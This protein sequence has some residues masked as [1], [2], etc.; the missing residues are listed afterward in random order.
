MWLWSRRIRT[1]EWS[2]SSTISSLEI[3]ESWEGKIAHVGLA[4]SQTEISFASGK[5]PSSCPVTLVRISLRESPLISGMETELMTEMHVS[6]WAQPERF[7]GSPPSAGLVPSLGQ[8]S[9]SYFVRLLLGQSLWVL[10]WGLAWLFF[11][12][13]LAMKLLDMPKC[14]QVSSKPLKYNQFHTLWGLGEVN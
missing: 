1:L 4:S 12:W 13:R 8:C 7:R 14:Y 10:A 5:L 3:V 2:F 6:W 11:G 9:S